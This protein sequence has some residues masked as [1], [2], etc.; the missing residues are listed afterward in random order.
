MKQPS[1]EEYERAKAELKELKH[2]ADEG[3]TTLVYSDASG[4]CLTP[5]VPYAWQDIGRNGTIR[6]PTAKSKRINVIGFLDPVL[7]QLKRYIKIGSVNSDFIIQVMD[8]YCAGI[9]K[10][11]VVVVDNASVHTSHAVM[12]KRDE[13]AN[14][15]LFIYFLPPYSPQLNLIEILWRKMKYEWLTNSSYRD[16][17]SLKAKLRE[18]FSSF[19]KDYKIQFS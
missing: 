15:G 5:E 17:E 10:L 12:A 18:I 13:W 1:T 6:M 14:K 7:N 11:T 3:D 19:G 8:C 16:L 9:T 4:F 2:M